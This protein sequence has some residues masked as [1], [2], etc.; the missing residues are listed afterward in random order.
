MY[1]PPTLK[2]AVEII[3]NKSLTKDLLL[4]EGHNNIHF[5]RKLRYLG[6]LITPELND[7]INIQTHINKAKA[8]MGLLRH[9]FACREVDHHVKY[10]VYATGP[11]S[12]LLWGCESWN[13]TA[14]NVRRPNGFHHKAIK[15]ILELRWEHVKE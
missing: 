2:E 6:A 14:K 7:D 15:R 1:F 11:L 13:M 9:F 3:K 10:W 4:N 5:N 12:T 8:Q